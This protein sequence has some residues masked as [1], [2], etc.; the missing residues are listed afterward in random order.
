M[1][2]FMDQD[3]LLKTETAKHLYHDYASICPIIDYHCHIPPQEIAENKRF[4]NITQ[5][6]LA[7]DHYKWRL[8]RANGIDEYYITGD[9]SDYD[10]FFKWCETIEKCIGNPLYHWSHLELQRYFNYNKPIHK[11]DADFIWNH[12]NS[13]LQK[14]ARSAKDL[15]NM[16]N[17]QILCTTDDPIDTLEYH[18]MIERD[19]TFKPKVYP[20]FRPD[21]AMNILAKDYINYIKELSSYTNEINCYSDLMKSLARRAQ[22]FKENG[23][24]ISD[25]GIVGLEIVDATDDEINQIF[26]Q[27]LS[28]K[29][30][31][32]RMFHQFQTRFLLDM[33]KIVYEYNWTMQLHFGCLRDT[34]TKMFEKL[35]KDTGY[36]CINT[37]LSANG[38]S[39]LLNEFQRNETLP[40]VIVYS[41]NPTDN[42]A[43][44]TIVGCFNDGKV[45]NRVQ[46]GAAWWFNDHKQGMIDQLTTFASG[47]ILPNFIGMLTDSRSFLSYCRH[48]Y[49]RRI[50]C[51]LLG[52]WIENGE[53][54]YDE[55]QMKEWIYA[56]CYNN[57]IEQFNLTLEKI[58]EKENENKS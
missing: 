42:A 54:P 38:L 41:L 6:W 37:S 17:V 57:M 1:R 4:E 25:H 40:K 33:S 45:V 58:E 15:I 13:I 55:K 39:A 19:S 51:D 7:K 24:F 9:A 31:T 52:S 21:R 49:F 35:G 12:C 20:T 34:N 5:L 10:K 16:S 48:E 32:T 18:K 50:L 29:E 26:I 14:E 56:I 47:N 22:Y 27:A 36:D 44:T 3:F 30:I 11:E 8:M 46:Q 23:C 43:L 53:F 2:E 28:S